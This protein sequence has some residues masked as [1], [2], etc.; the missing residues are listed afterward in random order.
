MEVGINEVRE[1]LLR[2]SG[3]MLGSGRGH[4][5]RSVESLGGDMR[6]GGRE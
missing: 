6:R 3:N 4:V 1:L 2:E 5:A